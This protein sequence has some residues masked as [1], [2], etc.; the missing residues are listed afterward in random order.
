MSKNVLNYLK[1]KKVFAEIN[2]EKTLIK[3]IDIADDNSLVCEYNGQ[4]TNL[5]SGEIT[6]HI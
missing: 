1:E 3:V 2:G 4:I 5:F 6:F